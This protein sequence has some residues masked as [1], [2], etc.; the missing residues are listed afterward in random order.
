MGTVPCL[1]LVTLPEPGSE[2]ACTK[3]GL[4]VPRADIVA[5]M[6]DRVA[7]EEGEE[8]RRLPI[9]EV[10]QITVPAGESCRDEDRKQGFCYAENLPGITC[11]NS[12]L[13]SKPTNHLVGAR[14]SL[15]C[16]Q[17]AGAVP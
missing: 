14:F 11:A 3:L 6:R 10:P 17:V 15:Q 1:V 9:C 16:I 5:R 13:F 8:S 7:S 12:L 2:E 4:G